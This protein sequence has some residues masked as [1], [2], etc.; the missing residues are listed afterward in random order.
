MLSLKTD[1]YLRIDICFLKPNIM[2]HKGPN[3]GRGLESSL[4]NG[5]QENDL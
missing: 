2:S 1:K 3:N 5:I 4:R